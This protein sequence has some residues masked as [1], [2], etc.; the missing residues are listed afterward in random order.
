MLKIGGDQGQMPPAD[1]S[2][3]Q[4]PQDMPM[5]GMPPMD[6]QAMGGDPI[7]QDQGGMPP[8]DDMSQDNGQSQ[9]DTNFDAGEGVTADEDTD[10]KKYIQQL[11]GKLSTTLNNYNNENEDEGLNKY[12][13]KMIVKAALKNASEA[14]KKEII[15]AINTASNEEPADDEQESGEQP[16]EQP[17]GGMPQDPMQMQENF[18]T[19]KKLNKIAESIIKQLK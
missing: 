7:M 19:K 18:T 16:M 1:P 17:E 6:P 15:K 2:M 3:G 9:F 11:T 5:D 14:T 8:M 4:Q 12:A 10:P 13:A